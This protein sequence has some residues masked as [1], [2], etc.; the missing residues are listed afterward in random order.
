[1]ARIDPLPGR[2]DESPY[3][4]VLARVPGFAEKWTVA[5]RELRFGG[6]VPP[7]LKE[8]VRRSTAPIVGC[9]F[10][11]SFGDPK[12][13]HDDPREEVAVRLART[14]AEDP[15]LVDDA[16]FDELRSL[17]SD[18]E[19]VELVAHISFVL[20]GGQ[21]FGAVLGIEPASAEYAMIYEDWVEQTIAASRT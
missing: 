8:E 11:A 1:M 18:D 14:I 17:F 6:S 2:P 7:E 9:Q 20:V 16:L 19:I 15:K 10:C 4:R 12:A 5:S 21:T 3:L 13:V